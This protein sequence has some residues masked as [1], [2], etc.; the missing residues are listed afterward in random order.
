MGIVCL[1]SRH[2]NE[3]VAKR[4]VEK[5]VFCRQSGVTLITIPY[6]WNR[7]MESLAKTIHFHRPD[8]Q[9]PESILKEDPIPIQNPKVET[10]RGK[11][12]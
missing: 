8:I 3:K 5:Q 12:K 6:W 10:V 4:D 11:Y 1:P 7:K 9:F 2:P